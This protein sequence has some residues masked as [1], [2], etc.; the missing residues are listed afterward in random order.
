MV[1]CGDC[2]HR[3]SCL[4]TPLLNGY[5]YEQL[6][7]II[8]DEYMVEEGGVLF[9]QGEL[10]DSIYIVKSGVTKVTRGC[11]E[12]DEA[13]LSFGF[14][15]RIYAF[16]SVAQGR[17]LYTAVALEN[18]RVCE[19]S[20]PKLLAAM[21][22]CPELYIKLIEVMAEQVVSDTSLWMSVYRGCVQ[23]KIAAFLLNIARR[24][25]YG[26]AINLNIC[27]SMPRTDISKYLDVSV[28]SLSRGLSSL[29]KQGLIEV[30]NRR[31]S[32]LN[33]DKLIAV[34]E[35]RKGSAQSPAPADLS[36]QHQGELFVR[37]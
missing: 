20:Y 5:M 15:W 18:T 23:K 25:A 17:H 9:R 28:E 11:G 34:A 19:I 2:R 31:V 3:S 6:Q 32:I 22:D 7:Q 8:V 16:E 10:S 24:T 26:G 30:F 13:V 14:A 33:L 4:V 29:S 12:Q 27:L 37:P 1:N 35:G 36:S 21:V